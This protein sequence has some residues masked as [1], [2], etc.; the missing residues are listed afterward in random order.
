MNEQVNIFVESLYSIINFVVF[1]YGEYEVTVG[2]ILIVPTYLVISIFVIKWLGNFIFRRLKANHVEPDV[3][4]LFRRVYNVV[5][6]VVLFITTLELVNVPLTAFAFVSG[7]IAIGV[8]FG[9]QNIINN[10][11]SGWILMW[12]RPIRIADFLEIDNVAKG[13]VESINTRSTRIRRVDGVH[14]LIP[15]SKLLENTVVNWTLIDHVM[16]TSV[17]V[18][19]AY[20]SPARLVSQLIEQAVKQQSEIMSEPA[21]III[22]DDFGDNALAFEAFFWINA[23]S[24]IDLR[25]VRSNVRY[26]ID[27]LFE[28]NGIV[29][30]FPQRDIHLDGALT[31][32]T[33]SDKVDKA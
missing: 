32:H 10:F 31:I 19:V 14:M 7:A 18:G 20:G 5:A 13:T 8:G 16:R 3:A 2:E 27:E 24:G 23:T 30:A 22:F 33:Q 21:P 25:V 12:E 15:N 9:A 17:K 29:I 28:Q 26:A 11:I 1:S 6:L 4:H